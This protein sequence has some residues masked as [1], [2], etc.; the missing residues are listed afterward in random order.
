[1]FIY[2]YKKSKDG[3]YTIIKYVS[4]KKTEIDKFEESEDKNIYVQVDKFIYL[5]TIYSLL[6]FKCYFVL[7]YK[8]W[9]DSNQSFFI[10]FIFTVVCILYD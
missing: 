2:S 7:W 6:F 8:L 10:L 9:T 4:G 1:M 5:F 3:K